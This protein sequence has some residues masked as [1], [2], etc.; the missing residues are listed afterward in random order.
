MT[1]ALAILTLGAAVCLAAGCGESDAPKQ[2]KPSGPIIQAPGDGGSPADAVPGDGGNSA[3]AGRPKR[4][5]GGGT[6]L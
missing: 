3:P 1:R 5:I 4:P 2:T 6:P